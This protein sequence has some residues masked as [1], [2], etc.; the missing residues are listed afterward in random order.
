MDDVRYVLPQD[1]SDV[2][3]VLITETEEIKVLRICSCT[4]QTVWHLDRQSV[5]N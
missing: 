4:G 2:K 3:Q 1:Q 5:N